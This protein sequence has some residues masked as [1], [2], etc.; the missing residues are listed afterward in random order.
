[1]AD[2]SPAGQFAARFH[3]AFDIATVIAVALWQVGAV[4][5][6]LLDFWDL[7]RSPG[8]AVAVWATQ[9]LIMACGAVLLLRG[10]QAAAVTWS[11]VA[12]D[13]VAGVAMAA[14]CPDGQQLRTNWAW[15][16]VGLVGV[17]LLLHRPVRQVVAVLAVNA[18]IVVVALAATG[19]MSRH[20]VAGFVTLLYASASIQFALIAGARV[21]RFSGGMAAEAAAEQWEMATRAAVIA[22]VAAARQDRYREARGL[23]ADVLRGLADG[24]VDPA[25]TQVRHRCATAESMLRQVLAEQDDVPDPLLRLLRP[26]IDEAM[27]RGV[28][29]E[30]AQVGRTPPMSEEVAVAL[31]EAPLAV[32]T[33]AGEAA[34]V[35]VVSAG[36]GQVS[37]SVLVDGDAAVPEPAAVEGVTVT[38]DRDG[39]LLWVEAQW[40]GP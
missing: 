21:F 11:L 12:V 1:M 23:I 6:A 34:R 26:G 33:G 25:D 40:D 5:T 39:D 38:C 9:L 10:T 28:V 18:G 30:M 32:L 14:N 17:L 36:T 16:S 13:L 20:A 15:T 4:G 29:V 22:E 37:V 31:A 2:S 8:L 24:T 3:R 35:T 19:E 27:R 7:Y